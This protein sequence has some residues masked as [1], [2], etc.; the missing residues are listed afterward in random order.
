MVN[1][2]SVLIGWAQPAKHIILKPNWT[3]RLSFDDIILYPYHITKYTL[4]KYTLFD[5]VERILAALPMAGIL[6]TASDRC[7]KTGPSPQHPTPNTHKCVCNV[8]WASRYRH[9][10]LPLP[11]SL[12]FRPRTSTGVWHTISLKNN[13]FIHTTV[14][15]DPFCVS[16][17]WVQ[18]RE[19]L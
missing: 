16:H 7:S 17:F 18:P 14:L 9:I 5:A 13:H 2:N 3:Y 12:G 6:A 19:P 4:S 1:C 10:L 11:A 8:L 15:L